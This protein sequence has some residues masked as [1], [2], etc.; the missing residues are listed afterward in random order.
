M[1]SVWPIAL[2]SLHIKVG[3]PLNEGVE[4]LKSLNKEIYEEHEDNEHSFRVDNGNYQI[5]IYEK[6]NIIKSV[7]YNDPSG[8]LLG[9]GKNRK[10]SLYLNRYKDKGKWQ[11]NMTNAWMKYY[12]N[13]TDKIQMVYGIDMD[14][15][16]F[17]DIS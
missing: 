11:Q 1:K 3:I 7:W 2:D 5:A 6:N 12:F 17:N 4:L 13:E 8:R 16:R 9:F 10:I 14:V 15:I